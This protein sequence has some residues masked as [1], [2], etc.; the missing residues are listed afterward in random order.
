MKFDPLINQIPDYDRF[1]TVDEHNQRSRQLAEKYPDTVRLRSGGKSRRGEEIPILEIGSGSRNALLFG[2]PHPNEPIGAM[3]LDALSEFLAREEKLLQELDYTWHIIKIIDV[4]GTRLNEGWFASGHSI[5]NYA[6]N[7][8][9]PPGHQQVEWT[10]PIQYKTMNFQSP[11]PETRILM[12]LIQ[13]CRPDFMYSLHNSGFGGA[14]YYIT[15]DSPELYPELHRIPRAFNIPLSLGEPEVPFF[16]HLAPAIFKLFSVRELYDH[17]AQH[18]E[19]DPAEILR[20]GAGSDEYAESFG[21][22]YSLV[23]EVPYFYDSR[24]ENEKEL[25]ITRRE[26]LQISLDRERE[27]LDFFHHIFELAGEYLDQESP[28]YPPLIETIKTGRENLKTQENWVNS[29]EKL[30]RPA[31]AAED[32]DNRHARDF[33]RVLGLGMLN[34]LLAESGKKF[35][36]PEKLVQATRETEENFSRRISELEKSLDYRV[37]PI[38]TLVGI[39]MLA[40]LSTAS[41]IQEKR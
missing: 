5:E 26:S 27:N 14:Y 3:M 19:K 7:F 39:Q 29:D 17:M 33:Y 40:G 28:F 9:R 25:S 32:F 21:S 31:T 1:F 16:E 8:Y 35:G 37:I 20:M 11:L 22:T 36:S 15:G 6:R 10:F 13:S 4:D 41:Y 2:C 24:V 34:R 23:T 18:T 12:D 38:K 30:E